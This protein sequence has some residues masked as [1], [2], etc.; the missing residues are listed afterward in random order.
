MR[1]DTNSLFRGVNRMI[2]AV[3]ALNSLF[4]V[5]AQAVSCEFS[6]Q[7]GF[8]NQN[9]IT[10]IGTGLSTVGEDL[11][12]GSVIYKVSD[13]VTHGLNNALKYEC[14]GMEGEE[15]VFVYRDL[16]IISQPNG[17]PEISGGKA[18]Y[19]TNVPG[20]GV[21]L[22]LRS[23]TG[24]MV[25]KYPDYKEEP[26]TVSGG[27][28][29]YMQAL[30]MVVFELVKTGPVDSSAS[31]KVDASTFP[32]LQVIVGVKGFQP[33]EEV[34]HTVR[35]SGQIMLYTKT[36]QLVNTDINVDLGNHMLSDFN[37]VSSASQWKNFD[38]TLKDCPPFKGYGTYSGKFGELTGGS[39]KDNEVNIKF[40]SA[41][42][43]VPGNNYLAMIESKPGSAEGVGI[44]LSRRDE[45][46]GIAMDGSGGFDLKQLIT[47][48][49]TLINIPLKARYVQYDEN[50]KPGSANSAVVFT[51]T[52]E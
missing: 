13:N 47:D 45:S 30:Q 49:S 25:S 43:S 52:Y 10:V 5:T 40:N 36:C 23:F 19:P 42:G 38:I 28:T 32:V 39:V 22:T 44:E 11:P 12:V 7:Y 29:I 48:G 21:V 50:I 16:K 9:V 17:A 18:I 6:S 20:V 8:N 34:V 4:S 1:I 26:F 24:P 37:G 15:K 46:L 27:Y 51:I 2:F 31:Q 33:K 3:L 14:P 41:Y 35:F